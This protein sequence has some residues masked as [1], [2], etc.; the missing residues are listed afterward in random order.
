MTNKLHSRYSNTMTP[1]E[2]FWR[3]DPFKRIKPQEFEALGISPSDI[4]PGTFAAQKH[5]SRF[6]S[7]FGGNAYGF[8]LF[9]A[10]NRL[11]P[12]EMDLIQSISFESPEEIKRNYRKINRIYKNIGLLIRFT[13]QG[14]PYYLIPH[15][16]V[17]SS[18]ATLKSKADEISRV[19]NLYR[20]KH[21][22]ESQHIGLLTR[23]NDLLINELTV[24]FKEH[25][26]VVIDTIHKLRH[27]TDP[28]DLVI[29]PADIQDFIITEEF[30]PRPNR[31]LTRKQ[32]ECY[33]VYVFGKV[34]RILKPDGE[35]LMIARKHP[36]RTNESAEVTFMTIQEKKQFTLF[37][38]IFRTSKRYQVKDKP[39]R[40]N[41][42]DLQKY[43]RDLYVE[44]EVIDRLLGGRDLET[45]SL[46]E[47]DQ[48]PYL[49]FPL[50][51]QF[52]YDQQKVWPRLLSLYSNE[53]LLKPLL[54][55]SVKA[56]RE[57]R[58]SVKGYSLDYMMV[59]LGQ[60]RPL[61]TTF[62]ELRKDIEES[63]LAGCSL[64]LLADYRDSFDFLKRTLSVLNMIKDKRYSGIPEIYIDRFRQPLEDKKRRFPAVNHV[65]SLMAKMNRLEKV[66]AYL[67]PDW[68]EGP[69]TKVL[70]ALEVFPFFGF[71]YGELKEIF[72]IIVGHTAMERILSGK[73][74]ETALNPVSDLA[75]T[76]D[77]L[78]GFNLLKYCRLMSLA[79]TVASQRSDLNQG[80]LKALLELF[81][82]LVRVV[83]YPDTDWDRLLDAKISS[84]GGIHN[85]IIRKILKMT[86]HFEFLDYW[87][88]LKDKGD[89]EKESLADFDMHKL[90]RIED[91]IK[92][93]NII[94]RFEN[95]FLKDDPLRLSIFYRKFLNV[96]FHGTGHLFERMDSELAFV[97]LWITVHVV[98]GE[99][100][101][102]NPILADVDPSE[103]EARVK[104]VEEEARAINIDY[105]DLPNLKELRDHLY[106]S[107]TLFV[108]GTGFQLRLDQRAQALEIAYIDMDANILKL[109]SLNEQYAGHMISHLPTEDLRA[110]EDLFANLESFCQ[111]H[112][113]L[114]SQKDSAFSLPAR[115]ERWFKRAED[116]RENLR[117]S[118]LKVIFHPENIYTDLDLLYRHSP[119]LLFFVIPE[120]RGLQ[121]ARLPTELY[122]KSSVLDHTLTSTRKIE[123]LVRRDR[124]RFQ[125]TQLLHRLAQKEFGPLTSGTI[126]LNEFQI[127]TLE[128]LVSDIGRNQPLL[129]ALIKSFIFHDLGLSPQLREKYRDD[130]HLADHA[131]TGRLFLKKEKLPSKYQMDT[132]TQEYMGILIRYHD[133][134]HHMIRGEFSIYAIQEIIGYEDKDLF[135][136]IFVS[137]F[138]MFSA[139]QEG[140]MQEDL[141]RRLFQ[142]RTVCHKIMEGETTF[143]D[144]YRE[145]YIRRGK[146]FYALEAYRREGLPGTMTPAEYLESWKRDQ[147]EIEED[148]LLREGKRIYAMD[149]ILRLRAVRYVEFTDL[150]KLIVK[151]PL[152]YIYKKRTYS[153]IGYGSFEKELFEA[154]R[155]YNAFLSLPRMVGNFILERLLTDEIRIFG[156]ENVC[157]YLSDKNMM[158]LLLISLMG[159]QKFN[160]NEGAVCLNFLDL[161]GKI[162]KRYEALNDLLAQVSVEKLWNTKSHLNHFF[163]AKTGLV[164]RKNESQRVL[165]IDFRDRFS[166]SQKISYMNTITEVEHLKNYYHYSLRA[167]RK[168]PF[169]TEDYEM[170]LEEAYDRRLKEITGLLLEQAKQQLALLKDLR[171]IHNLYSDLTDQALE[172]GFTEN[173]MY[174]LS[175]LYEVRKDQLRRE[176]LNEIDGLIETISDLQDLK[177][178]W[179]RT[180]GY[181]KKNRL[182]LGK[183]FENLIAKKFDE[184]AKRIEAC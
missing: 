101:N 13:G 100:V 184:A 30:I 175:D 58:F 170:R 150:A 7:R 25:Q 138:V 109:K 96:E 115:D 129:D 117:A 141:A 97:L 90:V 82:S 60:R 176:K 53:I 123:A 181:L 16:L 1:T 102:F 34:H 145:V 99:V 71:S 2:T 104:K 162:E 154:R 110:L 55:D 163:K 180:K 152:N 147:T 165:T 140:L 166:I 146:L 3:E 14:Q 31:K 98:R 160:S 61:E 148:C 84:I 51:G 132:T 108:L 107:H 157:I 92:L 91:V 77:Q 27:V 32:L 5:P 42:F 121:G 9:E 70:R 134:L 64:S 105:L 116:L 33:A 49:D 142:L 86:N 46:E 15:H 37:C 24:R 89:M 11:S 136:A 172:I 10:H 159:A 18:L 93:T 4:P 40:V 103:I 106:E 29:L 137:S 112:L 169:Q 19:I 23:G 158:M 78:K 26:F 47:M 113:R 69:E 155:I 143:E 28:L 173:Q 21:L 68:V 76:Y 66:E 59:Y 22:T 183:E 144:H 54:P 118:L 65:L 43:L 95:M 73:M 139:M 87:F 41:L 39:L 135:D 17:S 164:M 131:Q 79:E 126:G 38:H 20:V 67:N 153:G 62:G 182:F 151:V 130:I 50:D 88:E 124:G 122:T 45:W 149:R 57:K 12:K 74:N 44:Q 80:Q 178:Y 161:A 156:F 36:L 133:L 127:E 120:L 6:P 56:E 179:E 119:S 48:L 125:D 94:E 52:A 63:R 168:Y 177:D 35:I 174:G 8:G 111:S 75:R 85:E 81:D 114:L 171:E 72:L 83:T 167:L 128:T